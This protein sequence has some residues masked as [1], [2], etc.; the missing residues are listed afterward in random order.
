MPLSARISHSAASLSF[1]LSSLPLL[2]TSHRNLRQSY[3][4]SPQEKRWPKTSPI[5]FKSTLDLMAF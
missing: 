1:A 5:F 4:D 2:L 3:V